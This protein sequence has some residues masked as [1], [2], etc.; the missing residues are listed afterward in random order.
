MTGEDHHA[1]VLAVVAIPC[2]PS[3]LSPF[4]GREGGFS[5]KWKPK[6]VQHEKSKNPTWR[7]E[8]PFS[9]PPLLFSERASSRR[10]A[11]VGSQNAVRALALEDGT[12][13]NG[14]ELTTTKT[15][16]WFAAMVPGK[17]NARASII[18]PWDWNEHECYVRISGVGMPSSREMQFVSKQETEKPV[19]PKSYIRRLLVFSVIF[20]TVFVWLISHQP[21]VLFSRNESAT[22]SQPAVLFSQNKSAPAISHQPNE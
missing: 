7:S 15:V 10:D 14:T 21:A 16:D 3:G 12:E 11:E 13:R 9:P 8:T 18:L 17:S 4:G 20:N 22:S 19:G 6:A 5:W 1:C 2:V